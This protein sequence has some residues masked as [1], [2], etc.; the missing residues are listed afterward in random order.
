MQLQNFSTVKLL[1]SLHFSVR[2]W[3]SLNPYITI[4]QVRYDSLVQM[5]S[6]GNIQ[7]STAG[8][9]LIACV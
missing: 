4:R 8:R 2:F 7:S 6:E 5:T 3:Q 9:R 1:K